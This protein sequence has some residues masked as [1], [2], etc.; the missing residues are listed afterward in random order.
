[1]MIRLPAHR[2][3]ELGTGLALAALP[4]MLLVTG[5]IA[6][7]IW[8]ITASL[9][10]GLLLATLGASADREGRGVSGSAHAAAD[11]ALVVA[12]LVAAAVCAVTGDRTVA[13]LCAIAALVQAG[14]TVATR[15]TDR[16][17]PPRDRTRATTVTSD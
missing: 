16:P 15:Y 5:V 4:A 7:D 17:R 14:L 11:R 10:L 2:A 9:A 13:A 3:V 8:A 12:L 6:D 1:M